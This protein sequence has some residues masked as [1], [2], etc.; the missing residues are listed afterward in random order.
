MTVVSYLCR[1]ESGLRWILYGRG[2]PGGESASRDGNGGDAKQSSPS[3]ALHE[4]SSSLLTCEEVQKTL[5]GRGEDGGWE[6][7]GVGRGWSDC[8][9][10]GD[11]SC[12][13]MRLGPYKFPCLEVRH[14]NGEHGVARSPHLIDEKF[15]GDAHGYM[16]RV[17]TTRRPC[18]NLPSP[19]SA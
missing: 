18:N 17:R 4:K 2:F 13:S 1:R 14:G 6:E 5:R 11:L 16:E 10:D 8:I 7:G 3:A 12:A 19:P 15:Q 9:A